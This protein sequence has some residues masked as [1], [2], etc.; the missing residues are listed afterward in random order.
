MINLRESKEAINIDYSVGV[1]AKNN[2]KMKEKTGFF[3]YL[4][5]KGASCKSGFFV[6]NQGLRKILPQ[7][8]S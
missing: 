1:S 2:T 7:A 5:V 4:L 3:G 6:Q 8:Y